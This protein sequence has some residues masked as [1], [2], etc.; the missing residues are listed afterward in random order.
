MSKSKKEKKKCQGRE[1][2]KTLRKKEINVTY[3]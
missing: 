2:I 1:K 3:F